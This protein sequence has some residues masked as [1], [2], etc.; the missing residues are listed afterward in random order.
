MPPPAWLPASFPLMTFWVMVGD[1][2]LMAIPAPA[3]SP[4]PP[5]GGM[6]PPVMTKPRST[7]ERPSPDLNTT[8][9]ELPPPSMV[10]NPS[11]EPWTSMAL[12]LKSMCSC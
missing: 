1:E 6:A 3:I 5:S 2:P 8:T 4:G 12:P 10:V 9:R 7:D 11:R